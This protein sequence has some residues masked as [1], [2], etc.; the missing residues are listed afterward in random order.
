VEQN[1]EALAGLG[2][3]DWCRRGHP[4]SM[5]FVLNVDMKSGAPAFGTPEY[6]KAWIIGGQLARRYRL[7]DRT[8]STNA[9]N[10]V[11]AQAAYETVFSLWGAIM[12]GGNVIQHAAGW[13]EGGRLLRGEIRT[14]R[15]PPADAAGVPQARGGG[16]GQLL[17]AMQ[18]VGP[19]AISSVLAT[20]WSVIQPPSTNLL[21]SWM[22]Q[23]PQL[24]GG[25]PAHGG[26]ANALWNRR[27]PKIAS[28][29]LTPPHWRQSTPSWQSAWPRRETLL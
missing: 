4:S 19:A 20:R 15:R 28:P 21:I 27:W 29:V 26:E 8:S 6:M 25:W 16:R 18:E 14:R 13:M 24:G 9:A 11:D 7:P 10:S 5:G 22:A 2:A 23:L 3:V 12:G 1:A 17:R